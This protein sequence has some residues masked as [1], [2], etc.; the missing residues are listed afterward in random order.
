MP[1]TIIS[2]T[3][4]H[5]GVGKTTLCA[6]LLQDLKGFGAIKFTKTSLFTSVTDDPG[7]IS[8]EGKDTAVMLQAGA[9]RVVWVQSTESGLEDALHI[10]MGR[11]DGLNGVVVEGNTPARLLNPLLV[12]FVMGS[13][14]QVK[15]SA[16]DLPGRADII[17]VNSS[18]RIGGPLPPGLRPAEATQ[19]FWIDLAGRQGEIDKFLAYAK[20]YTRS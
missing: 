19:T 14:G 9:E 1:F 3:G 20:K 8:Q 10:A 18:G 16:K 6:L 12:I 13:D 7:I 17:V 4:A 5:S 2:V 11:M 15:P